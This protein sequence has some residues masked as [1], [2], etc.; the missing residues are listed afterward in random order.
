MV[1]DDYSDDVLNAY[2]K[3]TGK[4]KENIKDDPYY[5]YFYNLLE[6]GR[7]YV[8]Y[9]YVRLVKDIDETWVDAIVDAY[10]SLQHLVLHPRKFIEEQKEVVNVALARNISTDSLRHLLTHSNYIDDYRKDGTV[11]PN[12]ILNTFKEES[13]NTYENRFI[14]TLILEIQRFVNKRFDAIFEARK[15]ELGINLEVAS[16]VDNYTETID[17]QLNIKIRDKQTDVECETENADVY[18]RIIQL[19]RDINT[20]VNTEFVNI[21]KRYPAATHPIVKTNAI[22]KNKDYKKC[23]ELWNFIYSYNQVG[24]K[25]DL[26]QQKPHISREFEQD[27][28]DTFI[29]N[30]AMLHKHTENIDVLDMNRETRKK[31]MN[32][33]DIQQLLEEIVAGTEE[34]SDANLRSIIGKELRKIQERRKQEKNAAERVLREQR[35]KERLSRRKKRKA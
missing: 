31:E 25:I 7:N 20:L 17:Y 10:P 5:K 2:S 34:V 1:Y 29:W 24:Y 9:S 32:I 11:I 8:K 35:R 4:S 30:Y 15:D 28:Y 22:A 23:Y 3:M 33:R 18:G 14:C 6:T 13:L 21:V 12:K 16:T 26:L 19:H 27:I